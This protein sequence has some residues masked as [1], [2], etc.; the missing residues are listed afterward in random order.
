VNRKIINICSVFGTRPE[1]IKMAPVVKA[2]SNIPTVNHVTLV[3]GQHRGMLD[4]VLNVFD[5][6][7]DVD[8]NLM[9]ESQSLHYLT[10]EILEKTSMVFKDYE[11][12]LVLVHGDTTTA[13]SA[14]LSAFYSR[15]PIGHVEADLRT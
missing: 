9:K 4:Q 14:A 7:P 8:L 1:A 2:L 3:T 11:V 13:F 5:I 6:F 12:D 10:S 15:I